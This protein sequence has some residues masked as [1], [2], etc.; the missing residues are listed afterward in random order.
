MSLSDQQKFAL[1]ETLRIPF[2]NQVKHL[3]DADNLLIST[4]IVTEAAR[5]SFVALQDWIL[6]LTAAQEVH[7]KPYLDLWISYGVNMDTMDA[8][9]MGT[10]DGISSA[11]DNEREVLRERII[12]LVPFTKEDFST[13]VSGGDNSSCIQMWR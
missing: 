9:S 10:V 4:L 11:V 12:N 5:S 7:L 13:A 2:A 3:I 8:G 6:E 1:Y